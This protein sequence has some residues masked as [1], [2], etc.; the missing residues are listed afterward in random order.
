MKLL[1]SSVLLATVA[2]AGCTTTQ[3]ND[4]RAMVVDG[5]AQVVKVINIPSIK[6]EVDPKKAVCD[7]PAANGTM[8]QGECL[9]YRQPFQ[10]NFNTLSGDIQGFTFEPGYRYL[11]DIRQEAV[12]DEVSG[13][14]RPVWILN[15]V[16]SKKSEQL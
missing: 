13:V 5:E 6:I 3:L 7:I 9:Q 4:E 15:E 2:L 14:V 8:V 10:K 12:A 11:L 1:L 16:L